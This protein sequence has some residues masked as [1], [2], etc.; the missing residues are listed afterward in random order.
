MTIRHSLRFLAWLVPFCLG[1]I[2]T[3]RENFVQCLPSCCRGTG[4]SY[5]RSP[6]DP[7]FRP[8]SC[9]TRWWGVAL[10]GSRAWDFAD[11]C[12][13]ERKS[14]FTYKEM[15]KSLEMNETCSII[16]MRLRCR[17]PKFRDNIQ[18]HSKRF[19]AFQYLTVPTWRDWRRRQSPYITI[20]KIC[21]KVNS[22]ERRFTRSWWIWISIRCERSWQASWCN[23]IVS[24][25]WECLNFSTISRYT[26][27]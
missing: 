25:S 19:I 13:S 17:K 14:R 9:P 5:W 7:V 23:H 20:L 26:I 16:I 1:I 2:E 22:R 15:D 3:H 24:K 11:Q 4:P 27:Y 12:T 8:G 18:S 6:E 21:L 10:P